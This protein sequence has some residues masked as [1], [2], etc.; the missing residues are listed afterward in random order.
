MN[1]NNGFIQMT[2]K[3]CTPASDQKAPEKNETIKNM[4]TLNVL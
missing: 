4:S 3:I 1:E 2:I